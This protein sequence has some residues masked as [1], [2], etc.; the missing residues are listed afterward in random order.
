MR[1]KQKDTLK[2]SGLI[3]FFIIAVMM[4]AQSFA[5]GDQTDMAGEDNPRIVFLTALVVYDSTT[6]DYSMTFIDKQ[7]ANGRLKRN[8]VHGHGRQENERGD[9]SYRLLD[10]KSN[11]IA[12]RFLENPLDISIEIANEDGTLRRQDMRL[13]SVQISLRLQFTPEMQ[14]VVFDKKGRRQRSDEP[15]LTIDLG[16]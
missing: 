6:Q 14:Y 15:L 11:L 5:Q 7:V 12:E 2:T 3:K 16:E 9:F 1:F 13:D 8:A 10:R 4:V